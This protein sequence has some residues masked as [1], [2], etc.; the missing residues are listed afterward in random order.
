MYH[1]LLL[2]LALP[3]LVA[4][5]YVSWSLR[6]IGRKITGHTSWMAWVPIAN[7]V[8]LCRLAEKPAVWTFIMF[9]PIIGLLIFI[10]V[11][12]A[13]ARK[14]QKPSWLGAL[15]LP[16]PFPVIGLLSDFG[17]LKS[18]AITLLMILT[19]ILAAWG[20]PGFLSYRAVRN[21]EDPNMETRLDAISVLREPNFWFRKEAAIKALKNVLK[22]HSPEVRLEAAEALLNGLE[23]PEL[24]TILGMLE[25]E[26]FQIR[27][28]AIVKLS[29]VMEK[30]PEETERAIAACTQGLHDE[31]STVRCLAIQVLKDAG[32]KAASAIPNIGKMLN[33]P[34]WQVRRYAVDSLCTLGEPAALEL[35]D[36]LSNLIEGLKLGAGD[37]EY[38]ENEMSRIEDAYGRAFRLIGSST[39]PP[40]LSLLDQR[41]PNVRRPTAVVVSQLLRDDPE[42]MDRAIPAFVAL[43]NDEVLSIRRIGQAGLRSIGESSPRAAIATAAVLTRRFDHPDR[44]VRK[45]TGS[46][47]E[48]VVDSF[49]HNSGYQNYNEELRGSYI[50]NE[51]QFCSTTILP[52]MKLLDHQNREIAKDVQALLSANYYKWSNIHFHLTEEK[53]RILE[54]KIGMNPDR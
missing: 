42:Q 52:L 19:V 16:F 17:Y 44:E 21:L 18:T 30:R 12:A 35:K 25:D 8:Y 41:S 39:I 51:A 49:I 11:W 50:K 20:F 54:K 33:D 40:L 10:P 27:A 14:L 3:F 48:A 22:D 5:L 38:N 6:T 15:T 53:L 32:T 31:S 4:Y 23:G 36:G 45:E 46:L 29:A 7:F 1:L 43:M 28:E 47:L 13:V 9:I 37:E 26:S 34:S 2:I 24:M